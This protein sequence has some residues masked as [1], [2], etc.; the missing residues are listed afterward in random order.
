M[1][2]QIDRFE[3]RMV[4]IPISNL[5]FHDFLRVFVANFDICIKRLY[6]QAVQ[7]AFK[8]FRFG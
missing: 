5:Q 7:E 3:V 6:S 8:F 2:F 4:A 1:D